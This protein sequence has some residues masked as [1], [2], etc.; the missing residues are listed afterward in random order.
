MTG[1]TSAFSL[2]LSLF[3]IPITGAWYRCAVCARSFD[4]CS[5]CHDTIEHDKDHVFV[6]FKSDVDMQ[7]FRSV[8]LRT[9]TAAYPVSITEH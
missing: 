7:T 6:V 9:S 5:D 4:L 2:P 8:I 1:L 3:Q